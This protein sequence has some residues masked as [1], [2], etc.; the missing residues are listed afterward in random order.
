MTTKDLG[1]INEQL[2]QIAMAHK[3]SSTYSQYFT[4]RA[5]SDVASQI[6]QRQREHFDSLLGYLNTH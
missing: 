1:V 5:L 2:I 4:N 6:A 3:K